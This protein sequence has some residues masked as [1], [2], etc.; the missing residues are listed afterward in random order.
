VTKKSTE[1]FP[2]LDE[3]DEVIRSL[4]ERTT[5]REI[6][7]KWIK[8]AP[9][10]LSADGR[11]ERIEHALL[12]RR[13]FLDLLP[14]LGSTD[15]TEDRLNEAF[16]AGF[17]DLVQLYLRTN[18]CAIRMMQGL[19]ALLVD[20]AVV[21]TAAE[22]RR[23]QTSTG[24]K[25]RVLKNQ[26]AAKKAAVMEKIRDGWLKLQEPGSTYSGD[27]EFARQMHAKHSETLK[28]ERSIQNAIT[29]WRKARNG[30]L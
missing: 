21:P 26:E 29:R 13:F 5:L 17:E 10:D 4:G 20:Y 30:E 6:T 27:A 1:G 28:S 3:I 12:C 8:N 11:I 22:I 18:E 15:E 25:A 9:G 7:S 24:G 2:S 23:E 19:E 16:D 14:G